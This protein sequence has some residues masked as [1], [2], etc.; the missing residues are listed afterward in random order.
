MLIHYYKLI[1]KL[2][3]GR[4][5]MDHLM[6]SQIRQIYEFSCIRLSHLGGLFQEKDD[7]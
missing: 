7:H 2:Y 5:I 1:Y 6:P 3:R 4:I